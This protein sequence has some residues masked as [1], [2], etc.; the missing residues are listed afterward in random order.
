MDRSTIQSVTTSHPVWKA[1][2]L[3]DHNAMDIIAFDS[4][5]SSSRSAKI[6]HLEF[7]DYLRETKNTICGRHPIGVLL[8][9]VSAQEESAAG[10]SEGR[11]L[12][13]VKYDQSGKVQGLKDSSVSYASAYFVE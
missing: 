12:V 13:W 6:A 1:I 9:A 8:G 7:K 11:R 4:N 10:S 3:L 5:D 2:E